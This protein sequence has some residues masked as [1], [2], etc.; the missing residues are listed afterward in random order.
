MSPHI[1]QD[2]AKAL[3][4]SKCILFKIMCGT[5]AVLGPVMDAV[6]YLEKIKYITH[7]VRNQHEHL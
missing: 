4:H 5:M 3:M 6:Q 1:K 2:E 7:I